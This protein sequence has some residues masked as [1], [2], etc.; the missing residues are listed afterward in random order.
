MCDTILEF[1]HTQ[2]FWL[3]HYERTGKKNAEMLFL[4]LTEKQEQLKP[5]Y[6]SSWW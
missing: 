2:Q 1:T 4:N 6:F 3:S 5:R